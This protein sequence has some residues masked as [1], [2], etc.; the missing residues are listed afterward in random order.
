MS[1]HGNDSEKQ[2]IPLTEEILKTSIENTYGF[3]I[4]RKEDKHFMIKT[5]KI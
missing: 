4:G 1:E 5:K 3:I 2:E